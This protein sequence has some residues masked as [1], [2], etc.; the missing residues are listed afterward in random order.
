MASEFQRPI[1]D[2]ALARLIADSTFERVSLPQASRVE[3]A[4]VW[5][6]AHGF[7]DAADGCSLC[8]G[9]FDGVH[10]GHRRLVS[11]TVAD[12]RARD[13]ASVA[14]T[15]WPDPDA[16]LAGAHA[17]P[18]LLAME[19]RI[20]ALSLLGL[21]GIIA[22]DFT[23]ALSRVPY[24]RFLV[25]Q[26]ARLARPVS[27]HVGSNFR[28]GA[29]GEG[30]V[31]RM[32]ELGR[33]R[34]FEV[35]GHDLVSAAGRPVTATRIR[36]LLQG[37]CLREANDL[38]GRAHFV[39]GTVRHGRGEGASMGFAT[40]NVAC[41]PTTCLPEKGVY[42]AYALV[43]GIIWP[44]AVNVGEPPTFSGPHTSFLEAHLLGFEGDIY[45]RTIDV[46]FV[47]RLRPSRAFADSAELKR[48][49]REN[50]EWVRTHLGDDGV[51]VRR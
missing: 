46:V 14:V 4:R 28:I 34:G 20:K 5:S 33:Q 29:R 30:D 18:R 15:F 12:A 49:V 23:P 16:I 2:D 1:D 13:V 17:A 3:G 9:A 11:E 21:D 7:E 43:D 37:G 40:A 10:V 50:I 41:D 44:A 8:I 39:R 36:G 6:L 35:I 24:G 47:E 45:G 38:L 22:F 25:Q 51:E 27:V 19:D 48:V 42:A 31:A 26:L 32:T